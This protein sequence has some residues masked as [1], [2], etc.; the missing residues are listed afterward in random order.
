M[1][2]PRRRAR[3]N[4]NVFHM[5]TKPQI[6]QLREAFN[7]L[8]SDGDSRL[9]ASD[10][11]TF[12]ESIGSPLTREE[13]EE[14]IEEIKPNCNFM[15]LLTCIGEKMSEINTEREIL[16]ALRVFD[17]KDEGMIE[18]AVLKEWLTE[19]GDKITGKEYEYLIK[20][21]IE[22][23]MVDYRKL[24]SKMKHGEIITAQG[25]EAEAVE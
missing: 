21:C 13:I 2:V 20:G 3:Q 22:D 14:L 25:N 16:A 12:M 6:V 23:G 18:S 7:L 19:Q 9:T 11:T 15:M 17:E 24:A 5:L 1:G 10:I 8:D 4:S